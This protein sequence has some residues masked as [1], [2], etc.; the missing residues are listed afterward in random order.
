MANRRLPLSRMQDSVV[1]KD[2]AACERATFGEGKADS[3]SGITEGGDPGTEEDGVDVQADL[4]DEVGGEERLR[5]FASAHEADLF[6]RA[7]LEVEDEFG[8]V[9]GY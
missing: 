3:M 1:R 6:S 2:A 5:E 7:L 8:R 9:G 4:I